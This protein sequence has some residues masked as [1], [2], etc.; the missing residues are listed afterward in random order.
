[1]PCLLPYS[2]AQF[3]HRDAR[4]KQ[5]GDIARMP[6]QQTLVRAREAVFRKVRD[7]FK[8]RAAQFVIEILRM[9]LLLRLCEAG[10]HVG[11]K[12]ARRRRCPQL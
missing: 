3:D 11:R 6:A 5:A 12:F 7:G 9:Q 1:M 4:W 10:A 2:A 8:E